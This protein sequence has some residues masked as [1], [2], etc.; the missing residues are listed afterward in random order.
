MAHLVCQ[1]CQRTYKDDEAR[2]QCDCGGLLD[3]EFTP[4]FDLEKIA[5]RPPGMWRYR[6]AIPIAQDE[7][8]VSF[9][10]GFTPLSLLQLDGHSI[11]IKQDHLFPSGSYKDRGASVL[12]SKAKELGLKRIVEDSSGNA[13]CAIAAY[14][15]RAGIECEIYV[16]ESTSPGKLAQIGMYGAHLV[17][18]PGSREDTAYA[19]MQAAQDTYYAS[20]SWNPFFFQGTK[21]FAYEVC[22]QLGWKAP[23][24]LVLPVGNGT[25]LLGAYLG[26][27]ELL[28]MGIIANLPRIVAVQSRNCA[29]LYRAFHEG[30]P[31][32][33][34]VEKQDTL[35]EGIAIAEPVRGQQILAAV[36]NS[37]GTFLAVS[38]QEIEAA[39]KLMANRGFYIEPTAAATIAGLRQYLKGYFDDGIILSVITGH[40]LKSSEKMMKMVQTDGGFV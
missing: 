8:I 14:S 35:A 1:R 17:L 36:L 24:V 38:E 22:E 31:T 4:D 11:Y 23:D 9:D 10:E 26:F 33:P 20:H 12:I 19:V 34:M 32:V 21:T 18:V 13:G 37:Q 27:R 25:L 5:K 39:L 16:P 29:P 2:W 6:E 30:L 15:A 3:I 28:A 7:N 40:G